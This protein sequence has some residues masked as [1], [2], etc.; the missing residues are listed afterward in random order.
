MRYNSRLTTIKDAVQIDQNAKF[1]RRVQVFKNLERDY[2]VQYFRI[3][4]T[5]HTNSNLY[6]TEQT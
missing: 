2:V 3:L 5:L 6:R 1:N 4:S